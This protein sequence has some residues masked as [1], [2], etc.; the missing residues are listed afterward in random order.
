ML[1]FNV[2]AYTSITIAV[3]WVNEQ[4]DKVDRYMDLVVGLRMEV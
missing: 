4:E 1:K 3:F 2:L